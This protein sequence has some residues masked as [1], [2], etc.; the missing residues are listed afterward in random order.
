M[1]VPPACLS[2]NT[3]SFYYYYYYYYNTLLGRYTQPV[4]LLDRPTPS[5]PQLPWLEMLPRRRWSVG[6]PRS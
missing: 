2:T 5:K 6:R 1:C 3:Y 4:F